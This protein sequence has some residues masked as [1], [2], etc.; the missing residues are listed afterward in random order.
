MGPQLFSGWLPKDLKVGVGLFL[1]V[2]TLLVAPVLSACTPAEQLYWAA[3]SLFCGIAVTVDGD[4]Q[5]LLEWAE[6]WGACVLF[7]QMPSGPHTVQFSITQDTIEALAAKSGHSIPLAVRSQIKPVSF[8]YDGYIVDGFRQEI[9]VSIPEGLMQSLGL[10]TN[11]L[12][13]SLEASKVPFSR[14]GQTPAPTPLTTTIGPI[15]PG[16]H[17]GPT[18]ALEPSADAYTSLLS[19]P[20]KVEIVEGVQPIKLSQGAAILQLSPGQVGEFIIAGPEAEMNLKVSSAPALFIPLSTPTPRATPMNVLLI[21]G[22][23][24]P[25]ETPTPAWIW[26]TGASPLHLATPTPPPAYEPTLRPLY[27]PTPTPAT[28]DVRP[29]VGPLYTPTPTPAAT[30][31]RPCLELSPAGY[32]CYLYQADEYDLKVVVPD[33]LTLSTP[34]SKKPQPIDV[35]MKRKGAGQP[36][37]VPDSLFEVGIEVG[38]K[39]KLPTASLRVFLDVDLKI[40]FLKVDAPD[41]FELEYPVAGLTL[42]ASGLKAGEVG[43]YAYAVPTMEPAGDFYSLPLGA[44]SHVGSY[45]AYAFEEPSAAAL[46]VPLEHITIGEVVLSE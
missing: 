8:T 40:P 30:V 43:V 25:Q 19:V 28:I 24:I 29:W 32:S 11:E 3:R 37:G 44:W 35:Y 20:F 39:A 42:N 41:A 17:L 5:G 7:G 45:D 2:A 36:L 22:W 38:L 34:N 15:E 10:S 27:T 46:G 13:V 26:E 14:P 9:R 1:L 4:Y 23:T 18:I 12:T 16:V 21:P 33:Y 6:E 31:V